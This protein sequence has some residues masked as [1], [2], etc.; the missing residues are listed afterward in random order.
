MKLCPHCEFIYEDDQSVCDMD[1][2]ALVFE[3]T[4]NVF[5][6]TAPLQQSVSA[7]R[8]RAPR[9]SAYRRLAVAAMTGLVLGATLVLFFYV[10]TQ[11]VSSAEP[12]A[13]P[14]STS[15]PVPTVPKKSVS[16]AA[17]ATPVSHGSMPLAGE[18]VSSDPQPAREG[19]ASDAARQAPQP[20]LPATSPANGSTAPRTGPKTPDTPAASAKT[21]PSLSISSLPRVEPLPRLKPLPKLA[22][23]K[24]AK[25]TAR[26]TV[27]ATSR[28]MHVSAKQNKESRF[29]SFLKKTAKILKKPFKS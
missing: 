22:A 29:G 20:A 8:A 9:F 4:L 6:G 17:H 23:P 25:T 14:T 16:P 24:T 2:K 15:N 13:A 12:A 26:K 3:P 18:P 27:T 5:P 1:G 11:G 28:P 19:S 7:Q 21:A 10:F